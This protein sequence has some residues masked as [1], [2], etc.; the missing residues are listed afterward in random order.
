MF[1]TKKFENIKNI[2]FVFFKNCFYFLLC[3][4]DK[5][6][7]SKSVFLVLVFLRKLNSFEKKGKQTCPKGSAT[8]LPPRVVQEFII[9]ELLP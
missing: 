6:K 7:E 5:K 1:L 4:Q 3:F 2:I 9:K 8:L